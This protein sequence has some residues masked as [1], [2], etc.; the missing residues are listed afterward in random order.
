MDNLLNFIEP[1][2]TMSLKGG[3]KTYTNFQKNGQFFNERYLSDSSPKGRKIIFLNENGHGIEREIARQFFKEDQI[4]TI[5]EIYVGRSSSTV[6]FLELPG[7]KFN[8]VMF[9][10][11]Y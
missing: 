5:K 4:L 9:K 10:D 7:K 8:T 11:M 6:E 3:I 1:E 2:P